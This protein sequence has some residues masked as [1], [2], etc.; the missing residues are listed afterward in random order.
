MASPNETI[1]VDED[2]DA[3]DY[4][5]SSRSSSLS[6]STSSSSS[7]PPARRLIDNRDDDIIAIIIDAEN[8]RGKTGFELDHSDLLDRMLVWTYMRRDVAY[9]RTIAVIDHGYRSG[10]H[11]LRGGDD[12]PRLRRHAEG[13]GGSVG[14]G[15]GGGMADAGPSLCV[16]FAGPRIKADDVIARDVRW[17]LSSTSTSSSSSPR[18]TPS[19]PSSRSPSPSSRERRPRRRV[20]AVVTAD[21]ELAWRCRC[22]AAHADRVSR[23]VATTTTTALDDPILVAARERCGGRKKKSRAAR[24]RQFAEQRTEGEGEVEEEEEERRVSFATMGDADVGIDGTSTGS[25]AVVAIN[26]SESDTALAGGIP[27]VEVISPH[28]FLEDLDHAVH[29]WLRWREPHHVGDGDDAETTATTT[30]TTTMTTTTN[31][32]RATTAIPSPVTTTQDLFRLRGRILTLE[33]SLRDKISLH[34]R[35]T[36][37]GELRKCKIEWRRILSSIVDDGD[38][39][40]GGRRSLVS[41]LAWSLSSTISSLDDD[42]G[43][44]EDPTSSPP[45]SVSTMT[46]AATSSWE[47]L[48]PKDQERLLIQWGKEG[49]RGQRRQNA[50]RREKTEDRVVLAERLRRQ[51]ELIF[52]S[53]GEG[54][55]SIGG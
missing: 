20:V 11:L 14:G 6:S 29:E 18:T 50:A 9:G 31:E 33:S 38:R 21:R 13:E 30:T 19:S 39:D 17:L 23:P 40:V 47:R 52:D 44:G 43:S 1:K 28:A 7:P 41:S 36:T 42:G 22:A 35:G 45:P 49:P 16:S 12:G 3:S 4:D 48:A 27:T 53:T 2:D 46:V 8:V 24:M 51:L 32:D 10:A 55:G 26:D 25:D 54:G 5:A 34:R 15:G 37:M